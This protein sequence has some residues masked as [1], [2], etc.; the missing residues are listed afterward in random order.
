[1]VQQLPQPAD[2]VLPHGAEYIGIGFQ[3]ALAVPA[4]QGIQQCGNALHHRVIKQRT[5]GGKTEQFGPQSFQFHKMLL[6]PGVLPGTE[7]L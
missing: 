2:I 6:P 1:M 5:I 4:V 3:S 7:P